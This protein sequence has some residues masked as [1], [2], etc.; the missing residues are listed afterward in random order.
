M[1][2][3]DPPSMD[4]PVYNAKDAPKWTPK[5]SLF[6]IK[7]KSLSSTNVLSRSVSQSKML[8][9]GFDTQQAEQA[10]PA[11]HR[12]FHYRAVSLTVKDNTIHSA[13]AIREQDC[14]VPKPQKRSTGYGLFAGA[15]LK[16]PTLP[17]ATLYAQ[18]NA[19]DGSEFCASLSRGEKSRYQN[20]E[21]RTGT[22]LDLEASTSQAP[23]VQEKLPAVKA[24]RKS[25]T[26]VSF[27][28][29]IK[30][31]ELPQ[32]KQRIVRTH[33]RNNTCT[34]GALDMHSQD[35][36]GRSIDK[37]GDTWEGLESTVKLFSPR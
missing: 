5:M 31:V 35:S 7:S 6:M 15:L 4:S 33:R 36:C 10:K 12:Q 23:A 25:P 28:D 11:S 16:H 30:Q 13:R 29:M 22:M 37:I 18:S 34:T 24:H 20:S 9:S 27:I 3:Q 17:L 14:S 21:T 1:A 32:N 2:V 19:I 8:M 26:D